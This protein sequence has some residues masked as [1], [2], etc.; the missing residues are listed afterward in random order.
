M[1]DLA[2]L[3]DETAPPL[4]GSNAGSVQIDTYGGGR[5]GL[6]NVG[7]RTWSAVL[8]IFNGPMFRR[9][10]ATPSEAL[11]LVL[12]EADRE[13]REKV[14]R[15]RQAMNGRRGAEIA[16]AVAKRD[17]YAVLP[18]GGDFDALLG[19]GDSDFEALLA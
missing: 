13:A 6:D 11:R 15:Y 14:A 18:A 1:T 16:A 17:A 12:I 2:A 19:D 4:I 9:D 7:G 3:L 8:T 10:A 5:I